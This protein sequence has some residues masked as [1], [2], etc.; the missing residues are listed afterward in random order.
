MCPARSSRDQS[1]ADAAATSTTPGQ[2]IHAGIAYAGRTVTVET[3]DAT[4]RAHDRDE[5]IIEVPR[6]TRFKAHKPE[7]R[8]RP[9]PAATA[10][11]TL[12][13][14]NRLSPSTIEEIEGVREPDPGPDATALVR[15]CLTL[16][17]KPLSEFTTEDL[18]ILLGQQIAV[19][20]L[21]PMAAAV[22]A[23]DPLAEGDYYPG[24]LLYTVLR[25]P[26]KQW[27]GAERHRERLVEVLRTTPLSSEGAPADLR[28]AVAAFIGIPQT[29]RHEPSA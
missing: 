6:T 12:P 22:L 1:A 18:R 10:S 3:A 27:H 4:F 23:D 11:G 26:D 29:E 16:R 21:V 8:R 15:R 24:D 2:R 20:I 25:L 19:P 13:I 14:V 7:P 9:A 17:R 28:R 5:L